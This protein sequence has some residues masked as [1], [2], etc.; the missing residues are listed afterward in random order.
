M[1]RQRA[2]TGRKQLCI[3]E[4]KTG[5]AK[6]TFIELVQ[7][8]ARECSLSGD[9]PATVIGQAGMY[10]RMVRWINTALND[11][12]TAHKDWGWMYAQYSFPT[13]AGKAEYTPTEAGI[14]DHENWDLNGV[15]NHVTS[16]GTISEIQMAEIDYE[17]WREAYDFGAN[18]FIATRPDVFAIS[19]TQSLALGPYPNNLYTVTGRYYRIAQVLVNDTD[20]PLMPINYHM[21]IVYKAM[22]YYGGYMSAP[23]VYD[24]GE[25]EFSKMMR[26]LENQRLPTI[27]FG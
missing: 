3:V 1:I 8:A 17:D 11:I 20:I 24:R 2:R 13:I 26:R 15:R 5:F 21:M 4:I 9:G 25:L 27:A 16:I 12:E 18:R 19:P 10:A 7:R 22:M 14:L 23:E 6:V